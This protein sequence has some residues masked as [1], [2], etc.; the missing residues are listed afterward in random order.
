MLLPKNCSASNFELNFY[1]SC[2]IISKISFTLLVYQNLLEWDNRGIQ[3]GS[4]CHI[5]YTNHQE[6]RILDMIATSQFPSKPWHLPSPAPY[7]QRF[8]G[9]ISQYL[10][11]QNLKQFEIN[12]MK[13]K[14]QADLYMK[15]DNVISQVNKMSRKL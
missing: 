8:E 6:R 7:D 12:P 13:D 11:M 2:L 9:M 15:F 4:A 5:H 3:T 14:F 10:T 1:S